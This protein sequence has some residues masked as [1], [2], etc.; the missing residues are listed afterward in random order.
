MS[1]EN[2]VMKW[3]PVIASLATEKDNVPN[4]NHQEA[5]G[6]TELITKV[7][8]LVINRKKN[9]TDEEASRW[10]RARPHDAQTE[11]TP[12]RSRCCN[13]A[14]RKKKKK[15]K[16]MQI[17]LL[18]ALGR[19][20]VAA[21]A[22]FCGDVTVKKKQKNQ[23]KKK[24]L[25]G[26]SIMSHQVYAASYMK[27]RDFFFFFFSLHLITD[28]PISHGDPTPLSIRMHQCP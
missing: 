3:E 5:C 21:C 7:N 4:W 28:S 15:A 6:A 11:C 8:W 12:K 16:V 14:P 13:T 9:Y 23:R 27:R 24:T 19:E 10:W 20:R 26:M 2:R 1:G 18:S 17:T 22:V 25:V